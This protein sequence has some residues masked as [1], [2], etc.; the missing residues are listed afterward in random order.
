MLSA[1]FRER[2]AEDADF[3]PAVLA[4]ERVWLAVLVVFLVALAVF[5]A[6]V[7]FALLP[8]VDVVFVESV[9]VFDA[10]PPLAGVRLLVARFSLSCDIIYYSCVVSLS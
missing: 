8:A 4:A 5:F 3:L 7:F 10:V 9:F 2:E 6:G 1:F